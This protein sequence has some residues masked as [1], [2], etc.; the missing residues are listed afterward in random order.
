M[1]A[2]LGKSTGGR[3]GSLK[4]AGIIGALA[5]VGIILS[6]V[7][8]LSPSS[9]P[10]TQGNDEESTCDSLGQGVQYVI[11]GSRI[12]SFRDDGFTEG[13]QESMPSITF[14][15]KNATDILIL[16][17]CNRPELVHSMSSAYD[18]SLKLVAYA[19]EAASGKS[20]DDE[21]RN[22]L[23][24][25]RDIYCSSAV[26]TIEY[27]AVSWAESIDSFRNVLIPATREELLNDRNATALIDEADSIS[28]RARNSSQSAQLLLDSG[29]VYD[30]A[31]ALDSGIGAFDDL[32]ERE[33]IN[34]LLEI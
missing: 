7:S 27:E 24:G 20:G 12:V 22:S 32:I 11:S 28:E 30:A 25:H 9:A 31:I 6:P 5:L 21:L 13:G 2:G 19:C 33:D 1:S 26:N 10:S 16:E 17:Y 18:P 4:Y 3:S 34:A 23:E 15:E 8:P 29:L 14:A